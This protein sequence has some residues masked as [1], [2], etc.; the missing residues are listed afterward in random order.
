MT[1]HDSVKA[2]CVIADQSLS[3]HRAAALCSFSTLFISPMYSLKLISLYFYYT[4][5]FLPINAVKFYSVCVIVLQL[6]KETCTQHLPNAKEQFARRL[7][8]DLDIMFCA[9]SL[10]KD[11]TLHEKE[12]RRRLMNAG[13][14]SASGV[15]EWIVDQLKNQK[16]SNAAD[17]LL[18]FFEKHGHASGTHRWST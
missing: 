2:C 4:L 18:K 1:S 7:G 8:K 3:P 5:Y 11:S 12:G 6:F 10:D 16:Q 17:S 15:G 13:I 9:L 14:K